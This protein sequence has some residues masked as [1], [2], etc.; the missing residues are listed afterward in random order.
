MG[1]ELNRQIHIY[2]YIF[3]GD[4]R[5]GLSLANRSIYYIFLKLQCNGSLYIIDLPY[6][7]IES[8]LVSVHGFLSYLICTYMYIGVWFDLGGLGCFFFIGSLEECCLELWQERLEHCAG[9]VQE[10]G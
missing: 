3:N 4:L 6:N 5:K 2:I 10:D 9:L 7:A 1:F 8:P